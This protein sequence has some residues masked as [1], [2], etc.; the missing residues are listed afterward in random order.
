VKKE[1]L[2]LLDRC[3]TTELNL[4]ASTIGSTKHFPL[5]WK[6]KPCFPILNYPAAKAPTCRGKIG[7][8]SGIKACVKTSAPKIFPFG[9]DKSDCVKYNKSIGMETL[10]I[11]HNYS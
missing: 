7:N 1:E 11:T 10:E 4:T 6:K 9:E 8:K 5:I 2:K 3:G